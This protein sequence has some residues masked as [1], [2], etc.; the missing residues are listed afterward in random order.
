MYKFTILDIGINKI[1]F[2]VFLKCR[3]SSHEFHKLVIKSKMHTKIKT[4]L[5]FL[6]F[7][8]LKNAKLCYVC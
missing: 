8:Y 4:K 6:S 5:F 1:F 2:L 3:S 7:W